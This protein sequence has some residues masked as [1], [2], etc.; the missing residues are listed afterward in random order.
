MG[1]RVRIATLATAAGLAVLGGCAAP[2]E[3]SSAPET[4]V[5]GL[6][7]AQE[8]PAVATPARG[9]ARAHFD[10]RS[11]LLRWH[12]THEGLSG[13]PIAARIHGPAGPGSIAPIVLPL[14]NPGA[15]PLTGQ[16]RLSPEQQT[17]LMSGQWYVN[18]ATH[19]YPDGELRGQL[20][21]DR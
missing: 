13:P 21:A 1:V 10:S 3:L 12:V 20:R 5:A 2:S 4:F 17:Q 18:V 9:Q 8:V 7:G 14:G 16:V 15:M 11:Q 6:T 19:R